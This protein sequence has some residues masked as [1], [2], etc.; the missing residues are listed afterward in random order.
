MIRIHEIPTKFLIDELQRRSVSST[1]RRVDVDETFEAALKVG[2][3]TDLIITG[4]GAATILI[5]EHLPKVIA[6]N[7]A[8]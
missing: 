8:L 5:A 7:N 1:L 4:Q 3:H 6:P 2:K